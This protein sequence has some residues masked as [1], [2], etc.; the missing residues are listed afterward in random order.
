MPLEDMGEEESPFLTLVEAENLALEKKENA[1]SKKW[2][3]ES[4]NLVYTTIYY[5]F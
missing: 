2:A 4:K 1:H 3:R 5:L